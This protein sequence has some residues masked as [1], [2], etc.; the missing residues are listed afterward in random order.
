M[1]PECRDRS[2]ACCLGLPSTAIVPHRMVAAGAVGGARTAQARIAK[3]TTA[4]GDAGRTCA[5]SLDWPAQAPQ[6][7]LR[8]QAARVDAPDLGYRFR[9]VAWQCPLLRAGQSAGAAKATCARAAAPLRLAIDLDD[10][11]TDARLGHEARR[12]RRCI[13]IAAD[14]RP[15]PHRPHPRAA[16]LGAGAAG[17]GLGAAGGSRPAR[18]TAGSSSTRPRRGPLRVAGPLHLRGVAFD[19]PDGT[20]AGENVGG[21]DATGRRSI[22]D[23]TRVALDGQL[24]GGD[25]LFGNAYLALQ[26]RRS[27]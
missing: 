18:S 13:A 26:Q 21:A 5:C 16:G 7:T 10:A 1:L 6:G 12:A 27:R 15:D 8:V 22:G 14:A 25:M 4:G 11:R 17:P 9:D 24:H 19:T 20:I 23:T 3:V 2:Y